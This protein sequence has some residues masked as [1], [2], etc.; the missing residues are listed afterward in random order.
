MLPLFAVG[1]D[2]LQRDLADG[3]SDEVA[4]ALFR[5]PGVRV[6]SRRGVGHY[7]GQ[8]D[9][10]YEQAGRELGARYLVMGSLRE[11]NG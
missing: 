3:L 10:D 6:M 2:S 5:V 1:G 7:R 11:I 9:I 8:R 4:T